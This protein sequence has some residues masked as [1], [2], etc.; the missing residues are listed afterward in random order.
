MAEVPWHLW[1]SF[2]TEVDRKVASHKA[3]LWG[4]Q[5]SANS[6]GGGMCLKINSFSSRVDGPGAHRRF[7]TEWLTQALSKGAVAGATVGKNWLYVRTSRAPPLYH[8]RLQ[9][10]SLK[11]F[12]LE[13]RSFWEES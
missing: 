4:G 1:T 7:P 12:H 2:Q 3:S 6:T 9:A 11:L 8:R 5:A 10:L 13:S